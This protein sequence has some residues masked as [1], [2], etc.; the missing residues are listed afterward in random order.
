MEDCICNK[1]DKAKTLLLDLFV[2]STHLTL[3]RCIKCGG[4]ICE[5]TDKITPIKR[6]YL[7][8]EQEILK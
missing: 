6:G 3:L 7:E 1:N 5:W 8:N 4:L 2:V